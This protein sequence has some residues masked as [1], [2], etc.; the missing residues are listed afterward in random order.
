MRFVF[1]CSGLTAAAEATTFVG[2]PVVYADSDK[3]SS[4]F[5]QSPQRLPVTLSEFSA[6]T[7]RN[8]DNNNSTNAMTGTKPGT[9]RYGTVRYGT[10]YMH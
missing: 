4:Y 9:V 3:S 2:E 7:T 6:T 8:L 5:L 10:V 1:F